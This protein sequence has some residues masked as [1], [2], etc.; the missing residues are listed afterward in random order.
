MNVRPFTP[1]WADAF[2]AAI[3]A[4]SAYREA[5]AKWTWP[6]AFVLDAAPEFGYAEPVAVE[7]ALD[8]GRCHRAAILAPESVTA[9]F[10]L[11]APY[12]T[13]KRIAKGELDPIVAVTRG[14]LKVRGAIATLMLHARSATALCAC[15][16]DVATAFPD[17]D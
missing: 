15:A 13:W 16:R 7:L 8:R 11:S 4:S 10:V 14:L 9:P 12:A 17:E 5:G 1:A 2:R 3:E 6:M